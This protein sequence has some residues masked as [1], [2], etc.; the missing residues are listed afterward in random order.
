MSLSLLPIVGG[1]RE[2]RGSEWFGA[3]KGFES[4]RDDLA[5]AASALWGLVAGGGAG[6]GGLWVDA[7]LSALDRQRSRRGYGSVL[8]RR[9]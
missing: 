4:V 1:G 9:H 2:A 7:A 8:L 6:R 5:S 3:E